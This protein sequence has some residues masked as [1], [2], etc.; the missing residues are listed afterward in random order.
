MN[1]NIDAVI[2]IAG[3][4]FSYE[5]ESYSEP[6]LEDISFTVG[7]GEFVSIVGKS[8]CGKSTLLK[9]LLGL[10]KPDCGSI[11]LSGTSRKDIAYVSQ[12]PMLLPWR[13]VLQNALL[14]LEARGEIGKGYFDRVHALLEEY[15]VLAQANQ[16]PKELSGGEEARIAVVRALAVHPKI[17]FCDE[18]FS[19]VDFVTRQSLSI[20]FR[21]LC[22]RIGSTVVF[23]THNI[24][25]AM[26]L[27][28]RVLV[29]SPR[30][31][32]LVSE[33]PMSALP[34]RRSYES[35][36]SSEEYWPIFDSIWRSL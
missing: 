16:L 34:A 20:A 22:Q 33:H 17:L 4:R 8:G 36:R 18:P 32:K 26:F 15:G 1:P 35:F 24:E 21:G 5:P 19:A 25:E 11:R 28:D 13:T 9:I 29:L 6:T 2:E 3:L 30:P 23:V 10:L 7:R 12:K 27:S 31:A 14:G